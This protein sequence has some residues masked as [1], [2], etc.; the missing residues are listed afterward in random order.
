MLG[1]WVAVTAQ[2]MAKRVAGG[3]WQA[4]RYGCALP[5]RLQKARAFFPTFGDEELVSFTPNG[6][7]E[8]ITEGITKIEICDTSNQK[9]YAFSESSDLRQT[10]A[11][12]TPSRYIK[13]RG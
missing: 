13:R 9:S 1:F 2:K 4:S 6:R 3:R 8:L 11:F 10:R 5:L 7:V 12:R